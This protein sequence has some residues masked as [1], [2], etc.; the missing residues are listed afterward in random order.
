[1][2]RNGKTAH[3]TFNLPLN[4]HEL[5]NPTCDI[6]PNSD[7]G[8]LLQKCSI[9]IWD[10]APMMHKNG[11]EALNKSLQGV[12]KNKLLMGGI[13][14]VLAGDFR[15]ILPIVKGGTR[16]DEMKVKYCHGMPQKFVSLAKH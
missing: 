6:A 11:F 4:L 16:Y 12:K 1:M 7:I 10:E 14:V 5:D 15:K 2:L 8:K 3:R 9:I 13:L